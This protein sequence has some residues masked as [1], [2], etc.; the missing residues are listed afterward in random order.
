[1]WERQLLQESCLSPHMW[2]LLLVHTIVEGSHWSHCHSRSCCKNKRDD[3]KLNKNTQTHL[4]TLWT[5]NQSEHIRFNINEHEWTHT[6]NS[7]KNPVST[8]PRS[9]PCPLSP[10]RSLMGL[11]KCYPV[12]AHAHL[13]HI[14][15]TLGLFSLFTWVFYLGHMLL[16]QF[17]SQIMLLVSCPCPLSPHKSPVGPI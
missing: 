9:N 16:K 6:K 17:G 11:T 2:L 15:P 8:S 10:H 14:E 3:F 13:D 7:G 4:N 5:V 1:M 12:T